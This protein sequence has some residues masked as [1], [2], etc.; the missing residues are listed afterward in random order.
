[1]KLARITA[2][3]VAACVAVAVFATP[4]MA[5]TSISYVSAT[6][7]SGNVIVNVNYTC[8]TGIAVLLV[9]VL[10]QDPLNGNP[11]AGAGSLTPTCDNTQHNANVTVVPVAGSYASGQTPFTVIGD[12]LDVDSVS[13]AE[14]TQTN[15]TLS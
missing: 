7:S 5:T 6:A 2:A 3:T 9:D 10:N 13:D 11:L 8:T 14:F 1:M 12:L 15:V 4:A